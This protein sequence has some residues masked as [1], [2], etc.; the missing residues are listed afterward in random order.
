VGLLQERVEALRAAHAASESA[1]AALQRERDKLAALCRALEEQPADFGNAQPAAAR[2]E[3]GARVDVLERETERMAEELAGRNAV[4]AGRDAAARGALARPRAPVPR[5]GGPPR[6]RPFRG[7]GRTAP[8]VAGINCSTCNDSSDA[9]PPPVVKPVEPA[10]SGDVGDTRP[11][12]ALTPTDV[13][14]RELGDD[15]RPFKLSPGPGDSRA[16]LMEAG[17]GRL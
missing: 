2:R 14:G 9:L 10:L 5:P 6:R 13:R 17:S 4:V 1:R 15:S 3:G 12:P 11:G 8:S 7:S 16:K